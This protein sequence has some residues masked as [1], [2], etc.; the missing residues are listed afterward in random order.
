MRSTYNFR[1]AYR[2]VRPQGLEW[3][4]NSSIVSRL[5][6]VSSHKEGRLRHRWRGE[7]APLTAMSTQLAASGSRSVG[8]VCRMCMQICCDT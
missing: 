2:A 3:H 4:N 8:S 1:W 5:Q 7:D 6:L